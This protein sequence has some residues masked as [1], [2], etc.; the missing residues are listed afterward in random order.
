MS[1]RKANAVKE[2]TRWAMWLHH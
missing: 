2:E 1:V